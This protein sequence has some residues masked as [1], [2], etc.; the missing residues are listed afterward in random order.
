MDTNYKLRKI[1]YKDLSR[2]VSGRVV[3]RLIAENVLRYRWCPKDKF[4]RRCW[5]KGQNKLGFNSFRPSTDIC[6]SLAAIEMFVD[7]YCT[8]KH[9]YIRVEISVSAKRN[10]TVKTILVNGKEEREVVKVVKKDLSTA[11]CLAMLVSYLQYGP[12][13]YAKDRMLQ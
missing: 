6:W 4:G 5:V 3:D 9:N 13:D 8:S 1:D 2:L 12:K 10:W 11:L 7:L